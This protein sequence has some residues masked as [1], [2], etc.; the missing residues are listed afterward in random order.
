MYVEAV[1]DRLMAARLQCTAQ[2]SQPAMASQP[3]SS[4]VKVA[5]PAT[6]GRRLS[7][8]TLIFSAIHH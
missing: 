3:A 8:A 4:T 6:V 1:D 5:A 2:V 7:A